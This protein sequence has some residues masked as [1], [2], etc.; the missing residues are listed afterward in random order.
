MTK[1]SLS[2]EDDVIKKFGPSWVHKQYKDYHVKDMTNPVVL[3]G[4]KYRKLVEKAQQASDSSGRSARRQTL[5]YAES[6]NIQ[7]DM[8][9]KERNR[10]I[11]GS[12]ELE[13]VVEEIIAS[14]ID[15][16]TFS[17]YGSRELLFHFIVTN[18]SFQ[19]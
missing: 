15:Q 4:R 19:Y 17:N 5:E 1:F 8:I 3:R 14:Y 18:I 16:V 10:L 11:D 2:L 13:D 12:R 7:R 9:Y 6:M